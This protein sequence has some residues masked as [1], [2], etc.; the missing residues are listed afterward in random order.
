M[1][2]VDFT[3]HDGASS[4]QVAHSPLGRALIGALRAP[5]IMNTQPWR[6]RVHGTLAELWADRSRQLAHIDPDGRLL[7]LSCGVALHHAQTALTGLGHTGTVKRFPEREQ[8]DLVATLAETGRHVAA[9]TDIRLYQALFTRRTDRRGYHTTPPAP[10]LAA[11]RDIA[12]AH[13][14]HLHLL[15]DDELPLLTVAATDAG[16]VELAEPEY[17]AELAAWTHRPPEERDGVSAASSVAPGPRRVPVRDFV[18]GGKA[19]LSPGD[20]ADR[21][22]RYAILF[23]D[24]DTPEG[25]LT[26]GEALSAVLLGA[27]ATGIAAN[28]FSDVIEV[29]SARQVLRRILAGIGHPVMALRLGNSPDTDTV[30]DTPR[31]RARD[32]LGAEAT[33]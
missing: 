4:G 32:V 16:A 31:R 9:P 25:W 13:G 6:W 33:G 8:P 11:L 26:A 30:P 12:E 21:H 10:E 27:T 14:A 7:I 23:S 2:T 28:P 24:S 3:G 1:P 22:A 20:G 5:S 19:G 29:P 15:S 17:R 18:P